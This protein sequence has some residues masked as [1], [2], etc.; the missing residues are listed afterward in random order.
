VPLAQIQFQNIFIPNTRGASGYANTFIVQ[1]VIPINLN[2]EI[3]PYHIIRPTL[4]LIS[5]ADPDGPRDR[6]GGVG[7]L[8]IADVFVHPFKEIKTSAGGG[9]VAIAPTS[10][11]RSLGLGE[12][13]LGPAAFSI[14]RAV[15]KWVLGALVQVPISVESDAYQVQMQLI[16]TRLLEKNWY[17]GWGDTLLLFDDH[18]GNYDIPLQLRVGKVVT[19]SKQPINIFLQAEYT[20]RGF[21]S[22]P[23]EEWGIKLSITPLMPGLKIGPIF[24]RHGSS[25]SAR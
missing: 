2:S 18:N 23:G 13:Q 1:P 10:T 11:D 22:S 6:K 21:Q 24:D 19:L 16:A 14:T 9:Y 17:I 25:V 7:D 8:L 3:F 15:P 12:W 5:P 4:P 20:P